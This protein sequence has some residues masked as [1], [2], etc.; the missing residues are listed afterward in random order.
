[1]A[2]DVEAAFVPLTEDEKGTAAQAGV[3]GAKAPW[4]PKTI[5]AVPQDALPCNYDHPVLGAPT[6]MWPY[7]TTDGAI[8]CYVAR[9]DC[10]DQQGK[11]TK[12]IR[13][14]SYCDLGNGKF[15]WTAKAVP[16]PRP[17]Y[18]LP[19]I[20]EKTE[21]WVLVCEGEKAADAAA[22]LFPDYV[23]TTSMHGAQSPAKTDWTPLKD[24]IVTI[25]PDHD[26]GG[27]TY[28]EKV[29]ALALEAYAAEVRIVSVPSVFPVG[30]DLADTLPADFSADDLAQLLH[31][32]VAVKPASDAGAD[33]EDGGL[34]LDF[35][36]DT[37]GVW[38]VLE[39]KGK[40]KTERVCSPL[41]V[42]ALTRDDQG[43]N[44][45]RLLQIQDRDGNLHEWAMPMSATAGDGTGYRE[46][47][48]ALGLEIAP[49]SW[50]KN[51]L[52]EYIVTTRPKTRAR[53]VSRIGWHEGRYVLPDE[54]FGDACMGRMLL[55]APG[56]LDHPFGTKGSLIQWKNEVAKSCAG[57]SRLVFSL[58]VAFSAPLLHVTG[59]ESG[60]FHLRGPSSIGKTTAL[61][62]AGSVWG[63]GGM[64]G[65]IRTWRA[66]ANGLEGVAAMHCDA[67]LGLDELSQV[68]PR[69]AGH[70]A[71]MLANGAGKNRAGPSGYLRKTLEWRTAFLS[72][73]EISVADKVQ[74]DGRRQARAGQQVRVIDVPADAGIGRGL[75]EVLHG[76]ENGDAFAGSLRAATEQYYGSAI[77]TFLS[78]ICADIE[79]AADVAAA[80][81]NDFVETYCPGEVDGQVSRVAQR[82]GLVAAAGEL[83]IECGI[84]P[85]PQ[86]EAV[87]A[88]GKCF[89]DWLAERGGT[90]A[91]EITAG[92]NQVRAFIEAHGNARFQ[93][94]GT[95]NDGAWEK[96]ANRAGFRRR[97]E[98]GNWEFLVLPQAWRSEV[99]KGFDSSAS[100]KGLAELGLLVPGENGKMA[101]SMKVEGHG[102]KIRLYHL[103]SVILG[104]EVANDG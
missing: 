39:V 92:I 5:I 3:T 7:H 51:S 11:P 55:Q 84:V 1:V 95:D 19:Q 46:T 22:E 10:P 88:A 79:G 90:G 18:R 61:R 8:V 29:A 99:C 21:A 97:D 93:P 78:E 86:G 87:K 89:R 2:L 80:C 33:D 15:A 82:F 103:T 36:L 77:R 17:L 66:T 73:G 47:L 85:W 65:F 6:K 58:S 20:L 64:R 76:A 43:Q 41:K 69:E 28:A 74:E 24:R 13:P 35:Q 4:E 34:P 50:A 26:D 40:V 52:Q 44:W 31:D 71:Y 63:G 60:G 27:C 9:F 70:A 42:T 25:W 81:R 38:R 67:F 37:E 68:E 91:A 59:D 102:K 48:L 83:A 54:T 96:T 53:C 94:I 98:K 23:T 49:G 16:A 12:E 100:A 45:G 101:R 57:N 75:F 72:T 14:L 56:V 32:A 30:W 104:E 62:V